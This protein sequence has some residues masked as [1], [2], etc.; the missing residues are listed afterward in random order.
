MT[1]A[2]Y[3]VFACATPSFAAKARRFCESLA[4]AA[5]FV[6]T[7]G[8]EGEWLLRGRRALCC[9]RFVPHVDESVAGVRDAL[10]YSKPM[11]VADALRRWSLPVLWCDA[12]LVFAASPDACVLRLLRR[13]ADCAFYNHP[14]LL[15]VVPTGNPC[16]QWAVSGVAQLYACTQPAKQMLQSWLLGLLAFRRVRFHIDDDEVLTSLLNDLPRSFEALTGADRPTLPAV[17]ELNELLQGPDPALR[18]PDAFTARDAYP[19]ALLM[20]AV[21]GCG[22]AP[23][24]ARCSVRGCRNGAE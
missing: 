8:G 19:L 24:T 2:R 13:G 6:W 16:R 21:P 11:L 10:M 3:V 5:G 23:S 9:I 20:S 7:Q 14:A 18:H 12:D 1:T 15:R 17:L 4:A 22:L